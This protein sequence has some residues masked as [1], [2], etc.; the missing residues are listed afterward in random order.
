MKYG[1][2]SIRDYKTGFLTPTIDVNDASAR[3]NFEH[4]CSNPNSLFCSHPSDYALFKIGTYD[5]DSGRIEPLDIVVLVCDA[6]I[7]DEV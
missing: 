6:P 4:A 5:S 2:Y 1:V 3:R 7:S